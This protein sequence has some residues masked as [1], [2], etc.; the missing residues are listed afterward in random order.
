MSTEVFETVDKA[1][2]MAKKDYYHRTHEN[3]GQ[4]GKMLS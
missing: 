3:R 2:Y 1:S 4:S